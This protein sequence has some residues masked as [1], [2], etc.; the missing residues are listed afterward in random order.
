MAEWRNDV[1]LLKGKWE[2]SDPNNQKLFWCFGEGDW[3]AA[4]KPIKEYLNRTDVP[5]RLVTDIPISQNNQELYP[6]NISVEYII[7]TGKHA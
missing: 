5:H 4:D 2:P 3:S 7:Y 1:G 6:K